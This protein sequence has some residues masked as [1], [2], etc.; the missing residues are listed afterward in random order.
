[1]SMA[2]LAV[3]AGILNGVSGL[4]N[5]GLGVAN[6]RYQ[7]DLQHEIFAREDTSIQRRV[8][9]LKAA[10]LSPVLAAGQG[11]G[12]G[13]IVS[14]RPPEAD[15]SRGILEYLNIISMEKDFAIK[16]QQIQNLQAL[17]SKI[18][19]DTFK[20]YQDALIKQNDYNIFKATGT[21]SNK[22]GITGILKDLY[23]FSYSP[24]VN[25]TADSIN[26]KVDKTLRTPV[27]KD[28]D[29]KKTDER[30]RKMTPKQREQFRQDAEQRMYENIRKRD[31]GFFETLFN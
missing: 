6:Y 10:G 24:V 2:A 13:G 12:T 27:I 15:F 17:N 7:K 19:T 1:M 29:F 20:S 21:T 9:D 22:S 16:D 4:A 11:A 28:Y 14:T 25:N 23:G 8:A 31:R 5:F 26:K 18:K 3:G 30:L